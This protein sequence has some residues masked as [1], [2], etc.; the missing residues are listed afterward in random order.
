MLWFLGKE[1]TT[2]QPALVSSLA[3]SCLMG[4]AWC[5]WLPSWWTSHS[6]EQVVPLSWD[7]MRWGLTSM[8]LVTSCIRFVRRWVIYFML[9]L[10]IAFPDICFHECHVSP[11]N[12]FS[13]KLNVFKNFIG[14]LQKHKIVLLHP[15][16]QCIFTHRLIHWWKCFIRYHFMT[17]ERKLS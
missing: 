14:S 6:H 4:A 16:S 13:Q 5:L 7:T 15:L 3:A 9:N 11:L 10:F 8:N 2:L 17:K 1:H 12:V